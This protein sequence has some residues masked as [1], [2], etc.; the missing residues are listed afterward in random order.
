MR[1]PFSRRPAVGFGLAALGLCA[2]TT[3]LAHDFWLVPNAF[4]VGTGDLIEV[5]GQ[6]SSRFPTSEGAVA[7]ERVADARVLDAGGETRIGDLSQAGKSL[8]IRHRPSSPGQKVVAV[9]TLPRSVRE[10]AEGFRR[11][12]VLEGAPEALERYEREGRLPKTDSITRRYAKYAKTLVEVGQGGP[13]AF[14]RVAGHPLEFVPLE[15]PAALRTGGTFAVR[16][17]YRGRPLAGARV[18]ADRVP[19]E[20]GLTPEAAAA[21]ATH[22]TVETDADGVARVPVTG[23]GLWNVRGIHIVPADPGTG[24]DWDTHW[25]SLVFGVGP[26]AGNRSAPV[27]GSPRAP[28]VPVRKD[29]GADAGSA[30]RGGVGAESDSAAVA[31]SVDRFHQAL[32]TGDSATALALLAPDAVILESGGVETRAEYRGHHLPGDIA[33]AR[34]VPRQRSEIRVRVEGNAAW[35]TSTSTVQGEFRGRQINSQGAQ[36]MVLRRTADGWRIAA[37]HWS[38]R[39]RRP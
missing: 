25:V 10:S 15:D 8:L 30:A 36:L 35:A 12:I 29:A 20:P 9:S 23:G 18:H 32:A 34:A 4:V 19:M 1:S 33:F 28:G 11:Y 3:L 27:Q 13:R 17:L 14:D 31:R 37:V 38:S 22:G 26:T 21:Q 5:R 24:A 7:P 16:L 6:T 39:A 2:A